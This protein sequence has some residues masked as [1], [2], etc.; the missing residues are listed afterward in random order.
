[1]AE[2]RRSRNDPARTSKLPVAVC[3]G[4]DRTWQSNTQCH[5]AACHRQF[6]SVYLFDRH[7]LSFQCMEL[8]SLKRDKPVVLDSNGVY[9]EPGREWT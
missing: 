9:R 6:G 1:M 4:C 7:R 2:V 3:G 8:L 5:C